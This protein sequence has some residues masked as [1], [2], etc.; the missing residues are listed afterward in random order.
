MM[1]C[2]LMLTL[3]II[4]KGWFSLK[5]WLA[6]TNGIQ[7]RHDVYRV[8]QLLCITTGIHFFFKT[9]STPIIVF[10]CKFN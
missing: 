3:K 1:M 5:I 6:S 8:D 2:N 10:G 4:R 9:N 7:L